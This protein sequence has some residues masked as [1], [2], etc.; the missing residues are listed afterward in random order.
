[1]RQLVGTGEGAC[2]GGLLAVLTVGVL[3]PL[4]VA[5]DGRSVELTTGRLRTLLAALAVSAGRTVSLERLVEALWDGDGP[6]NARRG[7]H[8]Y[9]TRLRAVLGTDAITTE[10]GGYLLRAAP[11]QVD[12]VRFVRLLDATAREPDPAAQ[13]AL[14]D[15]ALELWRGTP[16]DG[17]RSEWLARSETP[18]LVE[19]Y[20]AATERRADLAIA[21]G[22]PGELVGRLRE[23]TGQHP[24]RESLW[25]RYLM[26]L[27][28]SGRQAEALRSYETIRVRLRDELGTDP[29]P[30]LREVHADL[31]AGRSS[32]HLGPDAP[33]GAVVP[34]QL[35]AGIDGFAGRT[36]ELAALDGLV[37]GRGGGTATAVVI[38]AIAGTAGVGKT[39]LAVHW[40]HR[41]AHRFPDGQLYVNLRGFHPSGRAVTR[42]EAVRGFLDAL[43]VPRH[44]IP[45]DV[46]AQV[47]LYRSLLAGRRMLVL[48]DNARDADQV[49]PLLPG[50]PACLVVVTSR[51]QLTSL[52]AA[53]A[54]HPLPLDP[55]PVGEARTLLA[56]RVGADRVAAEEAAAD[57]IIA[58]CARLP[59]A[60]AV[61]AAR[62]ATHPAFS[63]AA[64]ASQLRDRSGLDGLATGDPA[65]DARAVLSWSYR[66]L[67]PAAA[68]LFRLLGL[69]PGPDL[70]VPAAASLAGLP[71]PAVR[72]L[73]AELCRV[74]L[75]TEH[76]PGRYAFHDLLRAYAAE[77]ADDDP[78]EAGPALHRL[79]DHY[80]HSGLVAARRLSPLRAAIDVEPPRSGVTVVDVPDAEAAF[81]WFGAEHRALL[82]A[83]HRAAAAD[84]DAHAW[85]LALALDGYFGRKGHW[86]DWWASQQTAVAAARRSGDRAGQAATYRSLAGADTHLGRLGDARGHLEAALE[87]FAELGDAAGEANAHINLSEVFGR[88][89]R[90]ADALRHSRRGLELYRA[91]GHRLGEARALNALGWDEAHA[92]RHRAGLDHC[93]QALALHQELGHR[94][95]EAATW[96]SLGYAYHELGDDREAIHAY[97]QSLALYRALGN[98]FYEAEIL[99]HLGDAHVATGDPDAAR[100]AY[101]QAATVFDRLAHP[102]AAKLRAKLDA[103]R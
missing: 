77:L 42:A 29:G 78:V 60:L 51:D 17:V 92:G 58:R 48:L 99:D 86:Q 76:V 55:L 13:R 34:R 18:R 102:D 61:A 75:L 65:T 85:R 54:A 32:W 23:L 89:D 12:A 20:L 43:N 74:H 37:G 8:V 96:D 69:H 22:S 45:S 57:E 67:G 62:A 6:G 41:I 28:R 5:V 40:A 39:A 4:V 30:A 83:V 63:L 72:P 66:A 101:R 82:A 16:F 73:L 88:Q 3:G 50:S 10:P 100:D 9:L 87:L 21:D 15:E 97:Q 91:A 81:G 93:R 59:L 64:V 84:F 36:A 79:F 26:V 103:L 38:S 14:L 46:D 35:P 19:R 44:L 25:A 95:G 27:D 98:P 2:G 52:V 80:L 56:Q 53:E 71:V 90:Y 1:V 47:G 94:A 7:I 11:D 24:L 68:R 70:A 49:R 33:A 31:L